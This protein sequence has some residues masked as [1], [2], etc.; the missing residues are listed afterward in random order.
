MD[1]YDQALQTCPS[2]RRR[3]CRPLSRLDKGRSAE[4]VPPCLLQY[5][6]AVKVGF[7]VCRSADIGIIKQPCWLLICK[8]GQIL[9]ITSLHIWVQQ[10]QWR[11][12]GTLG[13]KS[14]M[15]ISNDAIEKF[16]FP[17]HF[18]TPTAFSTLTATVPAGPRVPERTWSAVLRCHPHRGG[19][20]SVDGPGEPRPGWPRDVGSAAEGEGQAVSRTGAHCVWGEV[21]V[22]QNERFIPTPPPAGGKLPQRGHHTLLQPQA[23]AP[24]W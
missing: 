5:V 19:R 21:Y 7:S 17:H 23:S 22:T 10:K 6:E 2:G 9:I 1:P 18:P 20:S 8:H 16:L 3:D 12:L 15:K 11:E 4:F 13:N 14:T 24:L